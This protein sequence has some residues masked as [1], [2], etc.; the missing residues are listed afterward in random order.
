[1]LDAKAR[2]ALQGV[3]LWSG[4]GLARLGLTPNGVTVMGL[5]VTAG[6]SWL[7]GGGRLR[8]GGIVLIAGG[9]LDFL[10]GAVAKATGRMTLLGS[11]LDSVTDRLSDGLL[12]AA[13]L[14]FFV[15]EGSERLV[16]VTI[17]AFVL[18]VLTSYIRAKAESLGLDCR[19][20]ILE[21]AERLT[22]VIAGLILGIL[23]PMLWVVVALG[24]VTVAQRLVHVGKQARVRT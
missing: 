15:A 1:M 6:G 17:A 14:W 22:L 2:Q 20:G 3:S 13:L 4:R 10:D 19:V 24:A 7:V 9:V 23:E 21:R 16:G 5:A 12:F 8:A 11:F 18:T